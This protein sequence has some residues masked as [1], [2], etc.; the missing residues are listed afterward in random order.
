MADLENLQPFVDNM[1]SDVKG[2][3]AD[4]LN[5]WKRLQEKLWEVHRLRTECAHWREQCHWLSKRGSPAPVSEAS[6]VATFLELGSPERAE[7]PSGSSV[8]GGDDAEAAAEASDAADG[9]D[10][11]VGDR[12][13]ELT[14]ACGPRPWRDMSLEEPEA[15]AEAEVGAAS[16]EEEAAAGSATLQKIFKECDRNGNGTINKRELI[17]ACRESSDVAEFFGLPKEIRQEDDS[18][19]QFEH[20]FQGIDC[21]DD[22]QLSFQELHEWYEVRRKAERKK[23]GGGGGGG[24]GGAGRGAGKEGGTAREALRRVAGKV[25]LAAALGRARGAAT[26]PAGGATVP[27]GG[28]RA[29][30]GG[31]AARAPRATEPATAAALQATA[32]VAPSA[33]RTRPVLAPTASTR[34]IESVTLTSAAG[35]PPRFTPRVATPGGAAQQWRPLEPVAA[36]P[37]QLR[38]GSPPPAE[39]RRLPMP[40][41]SLPAA[42]QAPAAAP[43]LRPAQPPPWGGGRRPP[44]WA[45]LLPGPPGG[46]YEFR[47]TTCEA[48]PTARPSP[49]SAG[50]QSP[51]CASL[52]ST[53]PPGGTLACRPED[54]PKNL[55]SL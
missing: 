12:L 17:K 36:R 55:V 46:R 26:V 52:A 38:L 3:Q 18:H 42:P 30:A 9:G 51:G 23:G 25:A 32:S 35:S 13:L 48:S 24:G 47:P 50:A 7:L 10:A 19:A 2:A 49:T 5:L 16:D 40:R 29:P 33:P 45:T 43:W 22:R 21:N 34:T 31:A 44:P 37:Q 41:A 20:V 39:A 4:A 53:V 28:A 1:A 27:A 8:A 54:D 6:P 15:E 11:A 14:K